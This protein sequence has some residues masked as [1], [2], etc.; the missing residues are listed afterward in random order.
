MALELEIKWP[1]WLAYVANLQILRWSPFRLAASAAFPL[2]GLCLS[3]LW[4]AQGHA[5]SFADVLLLIGCFFFTPLILML[6]L[7]LGRRRNPL[8]TGPFKYAFDAEGIHTSGPAFKQSIM[9]S[10]VQ[11]V[12]ESGSF[13]FFFVTASAALGFPSAQLKDAGVLNGVRELAR[14][15]V[16]DFRGLGDQQTVAAKRRENAPPTERKRS[17]E[18]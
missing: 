1:F 14:E 18:F 15:R 17:R 9:W 3:S 6:T 12:R 5:L 13:L 10:G 8:S 11:R 4:F 7:F 2:A 16:R